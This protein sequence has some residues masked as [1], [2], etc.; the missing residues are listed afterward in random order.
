MYNTKYILLFFFLSFCCRINAQ[1]V[2]PSETW[3][4]AVNLTSVMDPA[5][6]TELSSLFWNSSTK[7]LYVSHGDGRLRVL[8]LNS[9]TNTFSQIADRV[10]TG[11][12]E[13]ITQVN[14]TANEFYTVDEDN[15]QIR[16]YI[17]PSNF[18]SVTLINSWNLLAAPSTMTNTA[19]TGPEGIAFVPDSFLLAAGFV[20]QHTGN[21][22]TSI[23]GMGGLIFIA[24]QY[25][26]YVWVFDVNPNVSNDFNFVGKYR[27]NKNESCDLAFDRTTGLLYILHNISGNSLEV[28]DLTST[29]LPAGERKFSIVNEYFIPNPTGNLNVEGFAITPKCTDSSNVSVWLCR[30]VEIAEATAYKQ[31]C[32][33]WFNPFSAP[34]S[35]GN[36]VSVTLNVRLFIEGYYKSFET[37][38]ASVNPTL[39]PLLCDTVQI[40][41]H[42]SSP[43][44]TLIQSKKGTIDINGNGSLVFSQISL[45][46]IYYVVVRHRNSLET[47]STNP[48]VF[49]STTISYSF[50]NAAN[51]AFGNRIK[52]MGDG[53]FALYSGDI[54]QNGII[55]QNDEVSIENAS[56]MFSYGY[57]IND[58]NGDFL[59]ESTDYNLVENNASLL[60]A[61]ARP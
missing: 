19:N 20:S 59:V 6:L 51:L 25:Q 40:E 30:D 31:D 53:R 37:M 43:P 9:S 54:D 33:R 26:G 5:G 41:L 22:Y 21:V 27:T 61:V 4:N 2:W 49:S 38:N 58:I 47:W 12:P 29:A 56:L 32:L 52:S 50:T 60:I 8:Q 23:K 35:C 13:G 55:D 15:Y 18:S 16:K 3:S 7:R 10:Y 39:Y 46:N 36:V 17:Y 11:G 45:G 34:G 14:L 28:T 44:Y 24:H 48:I 42:A 1:S 57:L